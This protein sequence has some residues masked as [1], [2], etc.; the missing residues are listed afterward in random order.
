MGIKSGTV[1]VALS[2]GLSGFASASSWPVYLPLELQESSATGLKFGQALDGKR[3]FDGDGFQDLLIG[4]PG[5]NSP[6]GSV[7]VVSGRT[8]EAILGILAE[9]TFGTSVLS[10][11]D[12]NGDGVPEIVVGIPKSQ[13]QKGICQIL[14]GLDGSLLATWTGNHT[15]DSFGASLLELPDLDNDGNTEIAIGAIASFGKGYVQIRSGST[16]T[17]SVLY[18][19]QNP[20]GG[21]FGSG[22]DLFGRSLARVRDQDGDGFDDIAVGAP[23][24]TF[25]GQSQ[26]GVVRI[27]SAKTGT[28]LYQ[29][30]GDAAQDGFGAS[31]A[32]ANG[33]LV[34]GAPG[35]ADLTGNPTPGF[36]RWFSLNPS[37]SP[38]VTISGI[39]ADQQLGKSVAIVENFHHYAISG[40][41]GQDI[42]F[43]SGQG[44]LPF[45]GQGSQIMAFYSSGVSFGMHF[46][47]K[48]GSMTLASG[49]NIDGGATR[50]L[51][52]G[53][54]PVASTDGSVPNSMVRAY[55]SA[56]GQVDTFGESCG[57]T[58]HDLFPSVYPDPLPLPRL[59]VFGAAIEGQTLQFSLANGYGGYGV[60]LLFVS[61]KQ[62]SVSLPVFGSCSLLLDP[63]SMLPTVIEIPSWNPIVSG[64]VPP[65]VPEGSEFYFQALTQ[66]AL[67]PALHAVTNGI[68]VRFTAG[69]IAAF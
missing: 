4:S 25:Q 69:Q 67:Q 55:A 36:A 62:A 29:F 56:Q 9:K 65:G 43:I 14:S 47:G 50:E 33:I 46:L 30:A 19:L 20:V 23:Y 3:D 38:E 58:A 59:G 8:G 17:G 15:G 53:F 28:F 64:V 32:S 11:D 44:E 37:G 12:R 34:V 7:R 21:D 16:L 48:Q 52:M 49:G 24:A 22:S 45:L 27:Y 41:P 35:I 13:F 60:N 51:L 39:A 31:I 42:V 2:F 1:I 40:V 10:I 68:K 63:G 66:D 54:R 18:T 5:A 26:R 61:A 6:T 57:L